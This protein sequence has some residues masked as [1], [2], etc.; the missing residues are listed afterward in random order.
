[1]PTSYN[2]KIPDCYR[3]YITPAASGRK[4]PRAAKQAP[5]KKAEPKRQFALLH[6]E[7][8]VFEKAINSFK[9]MSNLEPNCVLSTAQKEKFEY[10]VLTG[11]IVVDEKDIKKR[12]HT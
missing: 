2:Y 4:P 6:L 7:N 5:T 10:L 8:P 9:L 3:Q 11:Q 12:L 1:M